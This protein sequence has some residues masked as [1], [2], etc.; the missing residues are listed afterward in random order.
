MIRLLV[1]M[2]ALVV[3]M[4]VLGAPPTVVSATPDNGA[5]GVDPGTSEIVIV[6]DQAMS[7][8]GMSIVGGG[9][10]FPQITGQ[11]RWRDTR[12]LVIPVKLEPGHEYQLSINNQR[13][14]NFR[15]TKGEACVPYPIRFVTKSDGE[16]V[17][18][19]M[20]FGATIDRVVELMDTMY[21]HRDRLG[22]DWAE[23]MD[24]QRE[25][26][27]GSLTP[28]AFA[29]TLS[30][31]LARARDK[32]I[33]IRT[34]NG[35][36]MTYIAPVA[37]N[38]NRGTIQKQLD[39]YTQASTTVFTGVTEDGGIPYLSVESFMRESEGD[40]DEAFAF[41]EAHKDAPAM[42]VDARFNSGGDETLAQGIAGCFVGESVGYA[43]HVSIDPDHP[44]EFLDP[45]TRVLEPNT[46]HAR[47]RGRVVVLTGPVTMSSCE[48]FVLMMKAAG[49]TTVGANTQGSSGN[50]R[51]YDLGHEITLL[52]PSWRPMTM[53]GE[54]FEGV[55]LAPDVEVEFPKEM[56]PARDPVLE[57]A[58]EVLKD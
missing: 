34:P 27:M 43:K 46:E 36:R 49:A 31:V 44:G 47:F 25:V 20:D 40:L 29:N 26:L 8:G 1:W 6:F 37:P 30:F 23:V 41:I 56:H 17:E 51:A 38:F 42:I 19:G 4:P 18:T 13:F 21:S 58:I 39:N 5:V 32:H 10:T 33:L 12:T 3:A 24:E 48:A 35:R 7:R 53:E 9:S 15:N 11:I 50:P 2:V 55:G 28:E 45:V 57:K 52:L 16:D 14:T 54:F 22:L